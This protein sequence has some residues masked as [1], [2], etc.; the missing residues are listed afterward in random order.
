MT[1]AP[2]PPKHA[3]QR[4]RTDH[5]TE[6][7]EDYVEAIAQIEADKEQC[8]AADLA[9]MFDVSHVTVGKTLARLES[10]GYV[11]TAPY[12]PVTLTSKGRRLASRSRERHEVVLEFLRSIGVKEATAQAD[13]EGIEHHVSPETL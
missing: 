2:E 12:A 11:E 6:T 8:R 3:F 9:R 4:T 10:E 1:Q 5:A 13:A 7:A